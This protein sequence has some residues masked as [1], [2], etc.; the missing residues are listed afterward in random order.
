VSTVPLQI[1]QWPLTSHLT[2]LIHLTISD[3]ILV[4]QIIANDIFITFPFDYSHILH[5]IIKTKQ[6]KTNKATAYTRGIWKCSRPGLSAVASIQ[7]YF[8][9][10]G[11]NFFP[12][13]RLQC[14]FS[15]IS[16][17]CTVIPHSIFFVLVFST[18]THFATLYFTFPYLHFPVLAISAPSSRHM[19]RWHSC[20]DRHVWMT[21]VRRHVKMRWIV[22]DV[23]QTDTL[24][25]EL[26]D[27]EALAEHCALT[28]DQS[29]PHSMSIVFE[30]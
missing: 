7:I 28:S 10:G 15:R 11:G 6:H 23:R 13:N 5:N 26:R 2:Y 21:F 12:S 19:S 8:F 30:I 22:A 16:S 25:W 29:A 24:Q 20:R 17:N 3:T 9:G 18:R 1:G 4:K 27:H 14:Y